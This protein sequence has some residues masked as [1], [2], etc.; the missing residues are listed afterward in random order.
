MPPPPAVP[1]SA[2]AKGKQ[3]ANPDDL[4]G[5]K[6]KRLACEVSTRHADYEGTLTDT[7]WASELDLQNQEGE[8]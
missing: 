5:S 4:A 3:K 8:M 2:K 6:R 1:K 7:G